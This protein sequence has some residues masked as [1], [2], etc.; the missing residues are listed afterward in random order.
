MNTLMTPETPRALDPPDAAPWP[1]RAPKVG[2]ENG[3]NG[4]VVAARG[5]SKRYGSGDAA[6]D[7][8]QGVDVGI[9]RGELTAVMGPSGSGKSTLMHIL[10]GLDQPSAGRIEI[11]G[12]D[13]TRL[14]EKKLTQL[15]RDK[16][17]FIFQSFN[18]LPMLNAR[19]NIMLPLTIA[20]RQADREW[21]G[22]LV[23]AVGL[24]DRLDHRP[25]ELSGGQQQRVAIARALVTRPTVLFADE[26]TGNLDSRTGG[27][28]L[29]LLRRSVD[30]FGQTI[31][32]VT[33]DAQ[34][35][36]IADRV[37]FL[38][39]GEIVRDRDR[40]TRNEIFDTVKALENGGLLREGKV[41]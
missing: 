21:L 9:R 3:A 19:E 20:G 29:A 24:A 26:P 1:G 7:A 11:D 28:V 40:M 41:S 35:A 2:G 16:V 34:A 8:L 30:D 38:K 37:L 22:D 10:A 33:H 27:E 6:V 36:S 5:L 31:V 39:D 14:K 4:A 18:L 17:G 13:I 15:R 12:T 23:E 32:M 25:A